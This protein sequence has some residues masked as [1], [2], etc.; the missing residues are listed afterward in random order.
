MNKISKKL[1][2]KNKLIVE[3]GTMSDDE[4][5]INSLVRY[6]LINKKPIKNKIFAKVNLNQN[7]NIHAKDNIC[8]NEFLFD[9]VDRHNYVDFL[10]INRIKKG[11][12]F[13]KKDDIYINLD[14]K[15]Y[16]NKI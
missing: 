11:E 6:I 12:K 9:Y 15:A 16:L 2:S 13:I 4:N 14:S 1:Q 10:D 3:D 5:I 8:Y 7:L